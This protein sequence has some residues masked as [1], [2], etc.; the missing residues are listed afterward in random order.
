MIE[1][2]AS[3]KPA[4]YKFRQVPTP[5]Q[6]IK[7]ETSSKEGRLG[8]QGALLLAKEGFVVGDNTEKVIKDKLDATDLKN[9]WDFKELNKVSRKERKGTGTKYEVWKVQM[10]DYLKFY[11]DG[12]PASKEHYEVWKDL[13]CKSTGLTSEEFDRNI[14]GNAEDQDPNFM[15][16]IALNIYNKDGS[17]T[18]KFIKASLESGKLNT[19]PNYHGNV[20]EVA[21][22]LFGEKYTENV[23]MQI[24]GMELRLR[25]GDQ[26]TALLAR[27]IM[28]KM[29]NLTSEEKYIISEIKRIIGSGEKK[30]TPIKQKTIKKELEKDISEVVAKQTI[31]LKSEQQDYVSTKK[32]DLPEGVKSITLVADGHGKDGKI[33][34][35]F[36]G[37]FFEAYFID[38][39]KSYPTISTEDAINLAIE[40]TDA[41]ICSKVPNGGSTLTAAIK[42][43]GK[44]YIAHIGDSRASIVKKDGTIETKTKNHTWKEEGR[45]DGK[46]KYKY[47]V[48]LSRSLGDIVHKNEA[49]QAGD[50]ISNRADIIVVDEKDISQIILCSDGMY[51]KVSTDE[52]QKDIRSSQDMEEAATKMMKRAKK[53][54]N[55][56]KHR[57]ESSDNSTVVVI[58]V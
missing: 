50:E 44:V 42:A 43:D 34:G 58:K 13:L 33:A 26:D 46:G 52:M 5:E 9:R 47:N 24:Q 35:Q 16:K 15:R 56:A 40:K 21:K 41:E 22:V 51:N 32:E 48:Q 23:L 3:P 12:T 53:K 31:G 57:G 7:A 4:E 14:A 27:R 17:G 38:I 37:Q 49:R 1:I 8:V 6:K 30:D 36:A 20:R 18:E 25:Q 45:I 39:K 10:H 28:N 11:K 54:I 55:E 29:K 2:A 19:D